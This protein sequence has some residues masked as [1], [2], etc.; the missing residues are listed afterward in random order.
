MSSR[1]KIN[2]LRILFFLFFTLQLFFTA[3]F[4]FLTHSNNFY[5]FYTW[6]IFHTQPDKFLQNAE[7]YIHQI[8]E[9]QFNPP[10]KGAKFVE[11]TFPQIR[12][13]TFVKKVQDYANH[14]ENRE[15]AIKEFNRLFTT[16]HRLVVWEVSEQK[17]N[18]IDFY[19]KKKLIS[20]TFL[21]KHYARK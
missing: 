6:K 15:K 14:L 10:Q 20:E 9:T 11:Q 19:W 7:I 8:D 3:F 1:K 17:F 12:I 13:Y 4:E 5:P 21:G 2:F 16:D 18:P